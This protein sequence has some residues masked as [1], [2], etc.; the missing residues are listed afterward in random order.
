MDIKAHWQAI[1]NESRA[2]LDGAGHTNVPLF[3]VT[4]IDTQTG[5]GAPAPYVIYR[6][7]VER[8][9]GTVSDDLAVM[10]SGWVFSAYSEDLADSLNFI[11]AIAS[12]LAINIEDTADGYSTSSVEIIGIQPLH[13][14]DPNIYAA[15][16][17]ILWER[18]L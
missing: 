18:S 14:P 3:H 10:R 15:H 1:Y 12:A 4:S 6:Q 17:R 13:D 11:T 16:L 5:E 9:Y 8:N 2:A 7:D